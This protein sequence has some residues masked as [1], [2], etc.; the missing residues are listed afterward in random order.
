M[1]RIFL[2]NTVPFDTFSSTEALLKTLVDSV[3]RSKKVLASNMNAFGVVQYL[4]DDEY[5]Q[6]IDRSDIIYPDGWGPVFVSWL[7]GQNLRQRHNV[8]DFI[9]AFFD[10]CNKKQLKLYFIG[11]E[12]PVAQQVA[13]Q[14][15]QE[16][17]NITVLGFHSGF[18]THDQ[19]ELSL[20][21]QL[22]KTPPDIILVGM[23]VPYQEKWVN[24]YWQELP[25]A[26]Y[27][28]VGGV[29]YYI[30]GAKRRAPQWMQ[31]HGLEWIYRLLQEPVRLF[32]RYTVLQA[33][34]IFWSISMLVKKSLTKFTNF[35]P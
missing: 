23:G 33:F 13:L 34:F 26:V 18:F 1:K 9:S 30:I 31:K 16:Y 24:K 27:M 19:E 20:V 12:E 32:W 35:G 28:G 10:V 7:D 17:P 11:C 22:Q 8:G 29:F 3:S 15:K 4:R 25:P 14:V 21:H 5:R 6:I 2:F